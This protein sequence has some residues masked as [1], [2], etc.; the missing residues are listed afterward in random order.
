MLRYLARR[1]LGL[2]PTCCSS[3]SWCSCS[4]TCCR[5]IRRGS[6]P[7]RTR[8]RDVELVR[9]DLGLNGPL[10]VAVRCIWADSVAAVRR[11]RPLDRDPR[12]GGHGDRR[13]LHAD[14]LAHRRLRWPGRWSSAWPSASSPASSAERW[15]DHGA[16]CSPS[17]AFRFPA[18]G[19]AAADQHVLGAPG[20]AAHRRRTSTW[21]HYVMPSFTLGLRRGRGHGALH[22]FRLRRGHCRRTTCA[23]RARRGC[24]ESS[25]V[26]RHTLRNALI[27]VITMTGLQ[28]GFLLGGSIV[29]ETVFSWPGLGRL[30][31][32]SVV[33]PRL[34]GDPG[35][36]HAVLA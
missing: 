30:L 32:D 7:G 14:V 23:P 22:P 18:S 3:A 9:Q 2:I 1:L 19:S 11:F 15:Q 25:V 27:P 36:D 34:P 26:W 21:Q 5:A 20:L 31:V 24:A 8:P 33:V 16:W 17:P 10:L 6:W 4:S 13:A 35:G 28:F 12:A 29:I